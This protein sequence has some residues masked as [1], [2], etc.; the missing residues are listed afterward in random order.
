MGEKSGEPSL[1]DL[2]VVR[3][4]S[5]YALSVRL[6]Y[7]LSWSFG[8]KKIW[9]GEQ[10]LEWKRL[11]KPFSFRWVIHFSSLLREKEQMWEMGQE[12]WH[13]RH[14]PLSSLLAMISILFQI[15][16]RVFFTKDTFI[17]SCFDY[18][19]PSLSLSNYW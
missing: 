7:S 3:K 10:R 6:L 14:W 15:L 16:P 1:C 19:N 9:E 11:P 13:F 2:S 5:F 12:F 8:P 18:L 17:C 4:S